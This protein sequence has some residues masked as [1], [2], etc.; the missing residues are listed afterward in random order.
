[1]AY[2]ATVTSTRDIDQHRTIIKIVETGASATSEYRTVATAGITITG[3]VPYIPQSGTIVHFQ[4]TLTAG[5][6]TTIKPRLG[7]S[8]AWTANGVDDIGGRDTS[9]IFHNTSVPVAF[10]FGP[11]QT[12]TLFGKSVVDA[13][14]DNAITTL[15][16]IIE[17]GRE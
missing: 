2:A 10:T 14:S 7:K 3:S 1:M 15:I 9:A 12:R 8:T 5:T 17:N 11:G 16:T 13:G 6:G 4:S